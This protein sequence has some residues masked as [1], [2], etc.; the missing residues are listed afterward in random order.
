MVHLSKRIA[1][2]MIITSSIDCSYVLYRD[3]RIISVAL[4]HF[5]GGRDEHC[6]SST[7]VREHGKLGKTR[8]RKFIFTTNDGDKVRDISTRKM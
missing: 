8:T 6:M 5:K 2:V 4:S 3:D 7:N 1:S